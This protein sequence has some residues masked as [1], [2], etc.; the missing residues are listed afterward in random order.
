MIR[1][2]LAT[3]AAA[4]LLVSAAAIAQDS[5]SSS[6]ESSAMDSSM[7]SSEM[8]SSEPMSSEMMS[9]EMMS[10]EPM[11]D[12]SMMSS[13]PMTSVEV[14]TPFDITTGYTQVDSDRLTSRI[15][16]QPVYDGTAADANNLGN[17]ND[18]VLSSTGSVQAV[19][20][21]V[22][23]FLGIGEKQVAVAYSALEWVVAADNTERFVLNTTV[24]QLTAAPDFV[25][26]EDTPADGAMGTTSSAM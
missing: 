12:S 3:T 10:S 15:V 11:T 23:G 16:G 20:I 22:G 2:L 18:L 8:M 21:G 9:S 19:V 24:E 14:A 6:M 26:T 17:I 7:M 1:T 13:A 4:A 25:V 5:S